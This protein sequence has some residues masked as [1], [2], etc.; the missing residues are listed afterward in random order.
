MADKVK[1]E[2]ALYEKDA[3]MLKSIKLAAKNVLWAFCQSNLMNQY[4]NVETETVW[5]MTW[6][7][8]LYIGG[9]A[10]FGCLAV[11]CAVLYVFNKKKEG[12]KV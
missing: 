5:N 4:S 1:V 12:R 2:P 9:I 3:E 10:V 8:G 6:W 11:A 7:R